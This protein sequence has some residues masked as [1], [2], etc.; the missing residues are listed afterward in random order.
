M[1]A[2]DA[3]RAWFPEM[4]ETLRA[5]WRPSMTWDEVI[6]LLPE[7]EKQRDRIKS[8][9][10][11]RPA[12]WMCNKCGSATTAVLLPLSVRSLLF[13]LEKNQII[14]SQDRVSLDLDWRTYQ[15]RHNLDAWGR[16]KIRQ[17]GKR[18]VRAAVRPRPP[19]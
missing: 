2:G 13:A 9:K 12:R 19:H 6:G 11:V 8:E 4:I 14:S 16:S 7:F 3:L 5:I 15:S 17:G 1:P 18:N 10:K